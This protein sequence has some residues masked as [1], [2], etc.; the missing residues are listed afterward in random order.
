MG[1]SRVV[2]L[3]GPEATIAFGETLGNSLP[4]G[5]ILA[6]H[7][8][9]GS[10]KT[11]FV[12]GLGKS[13]NIEDP[14][15]SPTFNYLHIHNNGRLPLFHFD[16]YRFKHESDFFALGFDEYWNGN[17]IVVMEWAEKI[18]GSLPPHTI[19]IHFSHETPSSRKAVLQFSSDSF[20]GCPWD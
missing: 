13:L 20:Q 16:L 17:G 15:H 6:L 14:I 4:A 12:Q 18:G 11:T 5:S 3:S 7:G 9:L 8:D 10:G 2:I 1:G 19:H